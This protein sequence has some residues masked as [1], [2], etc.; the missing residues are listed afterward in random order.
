MNQTL[1]NQTSNPKPIAFSHKIGSTLYHVN[2]HYDKAGK[3]SLEDKIFRMMK[4]DLTGGA[5]SGIV[6]EPQADWLSERGSV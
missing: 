1:T 2:V 3:E 4:N 6:Q 5:K